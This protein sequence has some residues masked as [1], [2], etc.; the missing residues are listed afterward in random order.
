[1]KKL[2]LEINNRY[3]TKEQEKD[4]SLKGTKKLKQSSKEKA[5]VELRQAEENY[6][7]ACGWKKITN[8]HWTP[9]ERVEYV[10]PNDRIFLEE[11]VQ[12]QKLYDKG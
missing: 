8:R 2:N 7:L 12:A 4:L 11:A 5:I 9:C 6:L 1:M 10:F 3:L